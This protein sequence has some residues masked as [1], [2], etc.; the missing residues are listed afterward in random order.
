[1]ATQDVTPGS[2]SDDSNALDMPSAYDV[3]DYVLQRPRQ[4]ANSEAFSSEEVLSVSCSL[5]V[6]P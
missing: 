3:R 2:Q 1:M 5:E 4:V 6:D